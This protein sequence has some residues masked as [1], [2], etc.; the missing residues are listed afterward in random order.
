EPGIGFYVVCMAAQGVF[1]FGIAL[2]MDFHVLDHIW[3]LFNFCCWSDPKPK[4]EDVDRFD[5][6]VEKERERILRRPPQ[7]YTS[8]GL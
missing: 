8:K 7:Y 2:L 6:D 1:F 5:D 3:Y 4:P